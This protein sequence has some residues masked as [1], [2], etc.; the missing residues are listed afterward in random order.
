MLKENRMFVGMHGS[1]YIWGG[2]IVIQSL[3]KDGYTGFLMTD[4]QL[5][6]DLKDDLAWTSYF[7]GKD[8]AEAEF[9]DTVDIVND[10]S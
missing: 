10:G 1:E 7:V 8:Y 6:I 9:R 5:V 4:G 2:K 3:T